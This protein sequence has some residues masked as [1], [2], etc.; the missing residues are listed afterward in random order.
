MIMILTVGV[1]V[2]SVRMRSVLS[3]SMDIRLIRGC[4]GKWLRVVRLIIVGFVCMMMSVLCVRKGLSGILVQLYVRCRS[5]ACLIVWSVKARMMMKIRGANAA[6]VIT[7]LVLMEGVF[8]SVML[9]IV[10]FARSMIGIRAQ[11]VSQGSICMRTVLVATLAK[12]VARVATLSSVSTAKRDTRLAME[13]AK[14]IAKRKTVK[15]AVQLVV[16]SA[17]KGHIVC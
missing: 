17:K 2:L 11:N 16:Q 6:R 12:K 9:I 4:V 1:G 7:I 15:S 8:R 14:E 3:V 13:N 10:R 5:F